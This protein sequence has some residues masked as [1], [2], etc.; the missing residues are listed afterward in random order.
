MPYG[1]SVGG[2]Y[3]FTDA[4]AET[5]S[6]DKKAQTYTTQTTPVDKSVR[7]VGNVQATWDK[8]WNSYHLNVAINGHMQGKRYSSTYGYAKSYNQWDLH[9][10][11]T[12]TLRSCTIEPGIGLE[13][14]F[15]QR[16][17]TPW[18]SNFST[19]NPGRTLYASFRMTY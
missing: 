4:D 11:H 9:T 15:N 1:F 2:G 7:H 17:T 8:S 6:F 18:N 13:N 14:V 5:M 16:D 12:F 19:I 3:T 10:R